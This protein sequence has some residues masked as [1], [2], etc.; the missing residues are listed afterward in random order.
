MTLQSWQ[1]PSRKQTSLAK[2]LCMGS[3]QVYL[4]AKTKMEQ[5]LNANLV[6]SFPKSSHT[7]ALF[8]YAFPNCDQAY[9]NRP[10]ERKLY[11]VIFL[12]ISSVLN[13]LSHFRKLQKKAH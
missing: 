4:L 11:Q 12:L 2:T 6:V 5:A 13:K 1:I 7:Y 3:V 9:E 10:C 8:F